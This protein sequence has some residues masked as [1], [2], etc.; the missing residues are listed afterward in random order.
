MFKN[1]KTIKRKGSAEGIWKMLIFVISI[2]VAVW[3]VWY[4]LLASNKIMLK[5]QTQMCLQDTN[6]KSETL[7]DLGICA[8][9]WNNRVE[10]NVYSGKYTLTCENWL[11]YNNRWL[12]ENF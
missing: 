10:Y 11:G 2:M 4:F 1:L 5:S 3:I 6:C 7:V 9:P 8:T 12:I